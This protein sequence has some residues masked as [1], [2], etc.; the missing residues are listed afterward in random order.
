[1]PPTLSVCMIARDEAA[2]LPRALQ[3]VRA[4][5]DEIILADTGSTDNSREV[6]AAHG[7]V[8][9]D[10]P[11]SDDFSAARNA[12]LA[13]AT[14]D[15][16]LWLDAD[17]ELRA[18]SVVPLRAA[19]ENPRGLAH[20]ILRR[21]LFDLQHPERFTRSWQLRL[22][23]R[24]PDLQF[25]GRCHP[26]FSVQLEAV[27][28][29]A[30]LEYSA[31][32]VELNHFGY[33]DRAL[34]QAKARRAA[35]LLELELRDRPGQLY[36][37]VELGRTL[38]HFDPARGRAVLEGAAEKMAIDVSAPQATN[39]A[40]A[41][42]LEH[43]L[44]I[45]PPPP[46]G[47]MPEKVRALCDRWFPDAAPLLWLRAREDFNAGRFIECERRLR[48]LLA[49]GAT[50]AYDRWIGFSPGIIGDEARLCLGAC[51]I[52]QARLSEAHAVL[53]QIPADGLSGDAARQNLALIARLRRA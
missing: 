24:R 50:H 49:L 43:L 3:S 5:A 6:A 34:R 41:L 19:V 52:R 23:R 1:M 48:K 12:A 47:L 9:C 35:R 44:Q 13:R 28:R 51:L 11:W 40:Y 37:E 30:G 17:E 8:V 20:L 14:G 53:Q 22:F 42:I 18:E 27:A 33:I 29:G 2:N 31:L 7:A 32:D 46:A 45:P 25:T 10:F 16:I 39:P 4:V 26:H 15:W 36:Y 21:D 38:M